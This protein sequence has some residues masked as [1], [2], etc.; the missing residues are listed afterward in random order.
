MSRSLVLSL[1]LFV[2]LSTIAAAQSAPASNRQIKDIRIVHPPSTPPGTWKVLADLDA[3]TDDTVPLPAD[4]GCD[5][6]LSLNGTPIGLQSVALSNASGPLCNFATCNG[7]QCGQW[8]HISGQP[9]PGFCSLVVLGSGATAC[10][11]RAKIVIEWGPFNTALVASDVL[12]VDASAGASALPETYTADDSSSITVANNPIG[13]A[14][15]FGDGTTATACPC[16]NTGLAGHGCE[17]SA[18]TGGAQ[19]QANGMT[20]PDSAVLTSSGE[21]ASSLS[22]FLQGSTSNASGVLFGDGVRCVGGNLK[23]LYV[24][25]AS[26]GTVSAPA[27]GDPSIT[28]M[29]ALLGDPIAVGSLRHYQVYYR[30]PNLAFCPAPPGGAFNVTN[31]VALIW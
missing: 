6:T 22:I 26:A 9:F 16:A 21:L 12:T 7:G 17:N 10:G 24:R 3:Y 20:S 25:N 18:A 2:P 1:L 8:S 30:D 31:A 23:R 15:C 27:A 29:S 5:A 4:L 28:A 13:D 14:Y 19:L 11:C